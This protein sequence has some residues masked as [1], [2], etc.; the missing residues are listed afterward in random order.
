[1]DSGDQPLHS[2]CLCQ[3]QLMQ[4]GFGPSDNTLADVVLAASCLPSSE[5]Q[6]M[7]PSRLHMTST[8]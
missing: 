2:P 5:V 8:Y 1:M 3:S 6:H 7:P 4:E